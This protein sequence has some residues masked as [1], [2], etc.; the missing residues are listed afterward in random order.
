MVVLWGDKWVSLFS[1]WVV[2]LYY[3]GINSLVED[4]E[5]QIFSKDVC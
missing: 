2:T 3:T 1:K 4:P 5:Y